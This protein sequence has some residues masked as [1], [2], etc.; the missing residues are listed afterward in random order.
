MS[1]VARSPSVTLRDDR[2]ADHPTLVN[3]L[4]SN[5]KQIGL[6]QC[7]VGRPGNGDDPRARRQGR[8]T[9]STS[10]LDASGPARTTLRTVNGIPN[11]PF[12]IEGA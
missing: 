8:S 4:A 6:G 9:S 7:G 10:P 2:S 12:T 5:D 3:L 1:T 11:H